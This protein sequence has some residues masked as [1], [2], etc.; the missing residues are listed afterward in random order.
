MRSLAATSV[1]AL[2]LVAGCGGEDDGDEGGQVHSGSTYV[3]LGD[4]YTAAG[5]VPETVD[6]AC[7][8]SS[9]NYPAL[10]AEDLDLELTDVSCNAAS[11]TSL[12][13][14]Q[15]TLEGPVPAQFAALTEDTDYVTMGIGG[16][17]EDF[18]AQLFT[19]CLQV[20]DTDP[21]GAPCRDAMN[22]SGTDA[23]VD[24]LELIEGRVTSA[25]VGIRDRSPDATVVM[26]GYPQLVPEEGQCDLLPLTPDDYDYVRGL[27]AELGAVTERAAAAAE[28]GYVDVLAAS[29]GH[30][31][32][33]GEDAWVN[34]VG[35]ADRA[36]AMHPFA[37]EQE[38]VADLV[39]EAFEDES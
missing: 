24:A 25:L 9:V 32:C 17:D 26:V 11:T 3:A 4:S 30:D 27:M 23:L 2:L 8:R 33:A 35:P 29:D 31:I 16:N 39:A 5:G 38:A 15:Q 28:V 6:A 18:L 13:G 7:G 37:E 20:R 1:L 21:D 34:G 14:A 10:V 19:V 36:A 12:V 22:A